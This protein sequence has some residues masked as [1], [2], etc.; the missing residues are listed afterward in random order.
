MRPRPSKTAATTAT[1]DRRAHVRV[2]IRAA[3]NV[4]NGQNRTCGW[5]RN[6]SVGG[7]FVE[8]DVPFAR[9]TEVQVNTLMR[10]GNRVHHFRTLAWVAWVGPDGMGL[11]FDDLSPEDY[12]FILRTVARLP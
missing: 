8:T 11:Q 10:D 3:V 9:E 1:R 7:M 6:L 4:A 5:V 12:H 2:P